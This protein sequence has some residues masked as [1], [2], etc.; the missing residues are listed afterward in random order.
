L[1]L[2]SKYIVAR[3]AELR[4]KRKRMKALPRLARF[5]GLPASGG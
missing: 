5:R 2:S 1:F 3:R 4:K